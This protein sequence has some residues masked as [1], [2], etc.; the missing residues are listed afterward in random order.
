MKNKKLAQIRPIVLRPNLSSVNHEVIL[1]IPEMVPTFPI[2]IE[3][4]LAYSHNDFP[5]K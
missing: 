1:P 2:T 4:I 3:N 5:I